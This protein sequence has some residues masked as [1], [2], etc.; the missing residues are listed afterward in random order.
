M[1]LLGLHYCANFSLVVASGGGSLVVSRTL[2]AVACLVVERGFLGLRAS[3][4]VA[5]TCYSTGSIVVACG[6]SCTMECGIFQ[7]RD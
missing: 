2:T 1:A 4:V 7:I 5:P 3:A 6:L